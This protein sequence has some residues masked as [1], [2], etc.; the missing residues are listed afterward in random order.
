MA[1][2][3]PAT[4][5]TLLLR[6][7]GAGERLIGS[8][9][10]IESGAVLLPQVLGICLFTSRKKRKVWLVLWHMLLMSPALVV[11]G[12]LAR[13]PGAMSPRAVSIALL[14][15]FGWFQT[16]MGVIVA[17]W[18]DWLAHLFGPEIRGRVF[19]ITS[20]CSA[21]AGTGGALAAGHVLR[22]YPQPLAFFYLYLAA[23]IITVASMAV[24]C[25]MKDPAADA[26]DDAPL[27]GT[28]G[29]LDSFRASLGDRNFRAYI[30]G[31][32]IATGGFCIGPF[33][34]VY[35]TSAAGG[36]LAPSLV[37]SLGAA[38]T[39]GSSIGFIVL[40][41]MGDATGHRL[42][43]MAG[44]AAQMAALAVMIVSAG[45]ISCMIAFFGA[46]LAAAGGFLSHT[47]MLY[48]TCPHDSRI[49][50][51]TVGNLVI[52]VASILCP[53][54]AGAAAARYGT[55]SL[56]GVCLVLSIAALL[57]FA[58]RVREPRQLMEETMNDER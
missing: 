25:L 43:V 17:V 47:N 40:G 8:V 50:H 13:A 54:L 37:V 56:F 11:M 16:A 20:C 2:V 18:L 36:G 22:T 38:T 21:L 15:C 9:G 42:G 7:Y 51:I 53:L 28:M 27:A 33:I 48:E 46:G 12:V 39:V 44:I 58:F 4:V 3:A 24:F 19:G 32:V 1:M 52:G 29:L 6:H 41:R 34:T 10:A 26:A 55:R 23:S 14:V 5:L 31:R 49:A 57:W 30:V 45:R 35:Y